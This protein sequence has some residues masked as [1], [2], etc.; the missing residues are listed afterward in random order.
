M[1]P[2]GRLRPHER[3]PR[4]VRRRRRASVV[5]LP[6][7]ALLS[8]LATASPSRAL[9]PTA[10][11]TQYLQTAYQDGLPQGTV[12][13]IEQDRDG[14]LWLGTQE[15]LVRFDGV[16]FT[17]F[18]HRNAAALGSADIR[19][20]LLDR[21]GRLWIG[22]RDGGAALYAG[23]AF[24][25][26][27]DAEGRPWKA[28]YALAE[29]P[30]G[31]IWMGTREHGAVRWR[32]GR[33]DV[34]GL[35]QG[36]PTATVVTLRVDSHG[37][38]WA[39][40]TNGC[41]ARFDGARFQPLV[42]GAFAGDTV[43]N[44]AEGPDGKLWIATRAS[45]LF[46]L[47][48]GASGPAERV[49]GSERLSLWALSFDAEGSLFLGSLG[50][51]LLRLRGG[52]IDRLGTAQGFPSDAVISL[53]EDRERNL[54]VGTEG[55]GV[56]RLRDAPFRTFGEAEGLR[57]RQV[58]TVL[59]DRL[60]NVWLGTDGA[61]LARLRD[62]RLEHLGKAAGLAADSITALLEDRRGRLWVGTRGAGLARLDD[63]RATTF[64][65]SA[66][67]RDDT[68]LSLAEDTGGGLWVGTRSGLYRA[69]AD[70]HFVAY[71]GG[72][73]LAT[74]RIWSLAIDS[75]GDVLVGTDGHGLKVIGKDGVRVWGA[76]DGL[77]SNPIS[78]LHADDDGV[79]W[80]GTYGG[81]LARLTPS[82]LQRVTTDDGLA[83]NV[84]LQILDDE[85][86]ALWLTTNKGVLRLDKRQLEE[87]FRGQRP[88]FQSSLFGKADG[89]RSAEC[90]GGF[91]PAGTRS[92][93]GRLWIPT[94]DG[95]VVVDPRD[96]RRNLVAPG[97]VI[98]DVL[99]DGR[100]LPTGAQL[101][102]A[103]SSEVELS[104]NHERL[105]IQY[106]GLSLAEPSR[107]RFRYKLE[108]FDHDWVEAG[109]ERRATYTNLPTGRSY[110][111]RVLA[112]NN[113]GVWNE[114][115][116]AYA[117]TVAPHFWETPPFL[118]ASLAALGLVT[119]SGYRLR[120]RQLVHRTQQLERLVAARTAEVVAQRD[121]LEAANDEL[122]RLNHFKS[123]FLGI[124]A[125]DLKNPLSVIYGYAGLMSSKAAADAGL[126]KVARRI[127]ASANQMLTIVSD[128][129]D[130]T[131]ME[132]GKLRF[133][134][135]PTELV[136][137]VRGVLDAQRVM[138][139]DREIELVL[140]AEGDVEA[141]VDREKV[142]R[143]VQNLVSNAIRYSRQGTEVEVEVARFE[144]PPARS[145]ITVRD[146]GPGLTAAEI[147]R[148]FE[149]FERLAEKHQVPIQHSTGLGLS[150][151]KQFVELHGG[152]IRID[153]TPGVGSAFIVELPDTDGATA[154]S[155]PT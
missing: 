117:F 132:S 84:I 124:A 60:G 58:W 99:V 86:G 89:M 104:P 12:R 37:T 95:V 155:E 29:G 127:S 96:L 51:G 26:L 145:E 55:G 122:T 140:R 74:D 8:A 17:V 78:S 53:R 92:R 2:I 123:E 80:I 71:D 21:S 46:V 68:V 153:S 151:V 110:R 38:L 116:A 42:A 129:L 97:V 139:A 48:A 1:I 28:V 133:E 43:M 16:R 148:I 59:A 138:A 98:E 114:T 66:G 142:T 149:R 31:S 36:L 11:L 27:A 73:D 30:D 109:G 6:A 143:V 15:G 34:Y 83:D 135:E 22:T 112:A 90:N 56:V 70:D 134:R 3:S 20:L 24:K 119:W 19:A 79:V 113:D 81:G 32:D 130:T 88:G 102:T 41:L 33:F 136:E 131:A 75:R 108:G 152:A 40:G 111:F 9:E 14:Y 144:T 100:R 54:W 49:A 106:A 72:A 69:S 147:E 45:G 146:H 61:G 44:L 10:Q 91:Q 150:I 47:P 125:H 50:E 67:L 13:A 65:P 115:G 82:G 107:V 62:G 52:Q 23:G 120:V 154:G 101:E 25:P 7:L 5:V 76:D 63:G 18:D 93:D 141:R 121:Q 4:A 85:A 64:G 35:E 103:G 105:E 128:L 77:P 87:F 57:A 118:L 137:L 126:Q 39:G 94:N